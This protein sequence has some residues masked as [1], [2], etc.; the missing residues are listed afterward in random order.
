[1]NMF[2]RRRP[3]T[4]ISHGILVALTLIAG[5]GSLSAQVTSAAA[6]AMAPGPALPGNTGG[7]GP[8]GTYMAPGPGIG[9]TPMGQEGP[10]G[11]PMA[12]GPQVL[13]QPHLHRHHHAR[14]ATRHLTHTARHLQ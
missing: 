12:V 11:V 8:G 4:R 13:T 14:L 5:A 3:H 6:Q 7:V 2:V 1:M 9:D 10:G